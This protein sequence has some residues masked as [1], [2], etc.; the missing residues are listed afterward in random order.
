MCL[1]P[2]WLTWYLL[3]YSHKHNIHFNCGTGD[4]ELCGFLTNEIHAASSRIRTRRSSN[5]STTSS[6]R[7][8]PAWTS[9]EEEEADWDWEA[10]IEWKTWCQKE[11]TL[12]K[13]ITHPL[14]LA[15]LEVN[16]QKKGRRKTKLIKWVICCILS[17]D[18]KDT[19]T[20][21][22]CRI[23]EIQPS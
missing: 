6:H 13:E 11:K 23:H 17:E 3:Y 9:T 15:T 2:A 8:F 16:K 20:V 4:D 21:T 12:Q 10:L 5:C 14:Q 7:D 22:A 19:A 1:I 18:M